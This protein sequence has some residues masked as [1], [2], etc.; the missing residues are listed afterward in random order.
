MTVATVTKPDVRKPLVVNFKEDT[1][2]TVSRATVRT[3]SDRL[4]FNDTQTVLYALA[5]LRD[6]VIVDEVDSDDFKPLTKKQHAVIAHAEP[7]TRGRVIGTALS[8]IG[9]KPWPE[10]ADI[11]DCRFPEGSFPVGFETP[12]PKVRPVLVLSIEESTS[13]DQSLRKH[14]EA[15]QR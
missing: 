5:R 2:T 3:L 4:G 11:V 6:E 1:L 14:E 10:L 7:K 8:N 15:C 12:G 9:W 13:V